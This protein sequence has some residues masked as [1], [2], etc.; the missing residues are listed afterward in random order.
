MI[1]PKEDSLSIANPLL[2]IADPCI[3][4]HDGAYYLTGTHTSSSLEMWTAPDLASLRAVQPTT[5]WMPE[6]GEPAWHIWS[7]TLFQLPHRGALHWFLY[8]TASTDDTNAS[9]RIYALESEATTPLGPYAF[10]GQIRGMADATAIDPSILSLNGQ[11]Y[12][13]YVDEPGAGPE[14]EAN[15]VCIAPLRDP[16]TLAAPGKP[17]IYPDQPWERGAGAGQSGYPVAEGPTPLYHAGRTFIVYS[18][19]HTGN[20]NYCLGLLTYAGRGDPTDHRSWTKAGP[21]FTHSAPNRVYGPGRATFTTALDGS[22][23]WMLYH[24]KETAGFDTASR[25]TRAQRFG[26]HPDGTPDFGVPVATGR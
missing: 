4:C 13:L 7:P 6:A 24:A 23:D 22:E 26:W 19:S 5:V 9:H 15:V 14:P 17:L 25:T 11:R 2:P 16:L 21:V 1:E 12:L 10:R 3:V 8:F 20:Y 18:A